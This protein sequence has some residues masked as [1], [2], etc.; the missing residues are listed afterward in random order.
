MP[1]IAAALL[2]GYPMLIVTKGLTLQPKTDQPGALCIAM[3]FECPCQRHL[4]HVEGSSAPSSKQ[5]TDTQQCNRI[6][7]RL[8][9]THG[10]ARGCRS[11]RGLVE[12]PT[13]PATASSAPTRV[14]LKLIYAHCSKAFSLTGH[15]GAYKCALQCTVRCSLE[16]RTSFEVD[17]NSEKK[18]KQK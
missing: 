18:Q 9:A 3:G 12:I 7:K 14:N 1:V 2:C 8:G 4:S 13:A 11:G 17:A 16:G 6:L 5:S 15:V 10:A